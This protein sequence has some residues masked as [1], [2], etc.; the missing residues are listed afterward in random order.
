MKTCQNAPDSLVGIRVFD[1]TQVRF[2]KWSGR[3]DRSARKVE[4]GAWWR[5]DAEIE[6]VRMGLM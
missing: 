4:G 6:L 3:T 2:T 1:P 5:D